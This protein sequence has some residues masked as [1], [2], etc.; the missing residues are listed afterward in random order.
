MIRVLFFGPVAERVGA[1]RLDV[2][3]VPGMR[4]AD[5]R[6][7]LAPRYPEAFALVSLA[8]VDGEHVRDPNLALSEGAEVVFMSKFSGG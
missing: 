4:V 2:D 6:A 5:L 8:A 1:S 7:Q 3:F